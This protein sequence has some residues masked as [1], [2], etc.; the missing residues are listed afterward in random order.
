MSMSV[1]DCNTTGQSGRRLRIAVLL[2]WYGQ[3]MSPCA[4]IRLHAFTQHFPAEVRYLIPEELAH[5]RPHVVIWHRVAVA[6]AQAVEELAATAAGL[7]ARLVFDLDDNLLA[8]DAH[9]ERD[10]YQGMIAAVA[11]S[12]DV[13]DVVWCS[14]EPLQEFIAARGATA[15]WMP[16]ALDPELWRGWPHDPGVAPSGG[17]LRML[18]MGTRT[19]DDDFMLLREALV[20]LHRERP[21]SFT[22][23]L[24]GVSGQPL[25]EYDWLASL[26]PPAHVGASYPAFVRWFVG[27]R[28]RFDLGLAPLADTVFN[29]SKSSIK[30]LDY[31]GLGLPTLASR[32]PAYALDEA[33]DRLLVDNDPDAWY[34]AFTMA[35]EGDLPL[36][37]ASSRARGRIGPEHFGLA[38][39][40][41]WNSVQA[42]VS[43]GG[44]HEG[45]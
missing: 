31:A 40:Q 21:G 1:K 19:H 4:S 37:E 23:T 33:A 36:L 26:A 5:Y 3:V 16:N 35:L 12:V 9:S 43:N 13:A 14:T 17:R 11:K 15:E 41:R 29:R 2:E 34:E 8:M 45:I 22:L 10:K 39:K 24:V 6:S 32:V 25:P 20:R 42:L 30:V 18:Y 7:D 28:G 38:V 44:K 27:Q